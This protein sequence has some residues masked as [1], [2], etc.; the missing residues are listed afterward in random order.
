MIS[1]GGG[2]AVMDP[3][4]DKGM[5]Q[6]VKKI[7][8]KMTDLRTVVQDLSGGAFLVALFMIVAS[9]LVTLYLAVYL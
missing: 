8:K 9:S 5:A 3:I 6:G 2:E 7:T 1:R 4:E